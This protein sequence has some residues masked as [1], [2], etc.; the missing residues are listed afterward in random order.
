MFAKH[1]SLSVFALFLQNKAN[2]V[3]SNPFY[4]HPLN[5]DTLLLQTICFVPGERKPFHFL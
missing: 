4:G 5:T 1:R 3:E 2:M